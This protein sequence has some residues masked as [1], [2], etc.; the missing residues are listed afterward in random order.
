[1]CVYY[2]QPRTIADMHTRDRQKSLAFASADPIWIEMFGGANSA[3][4]PKPNEE[5]CIT[6]PSLLHFLLDGAAALHWYILDRKKKVNPLGLSDAGWR[7]FRLAGRRFYCSLSRLL[8]PCIINEPTV[9]HRLQA[10][11][12]LGTRN[13]ASRRRLIRTVL[14]ICT[15]QRYRLVS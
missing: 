3:A 10:N 6:L 8:P 9:I 2:K 15:S 12:R 11:Q 4:L 1:M 14:R 7:A 13:N 5:S